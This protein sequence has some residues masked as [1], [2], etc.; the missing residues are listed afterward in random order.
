MEHGQQVT[1][2][3]FTLLGE[4]GALTGGRKDELRRR[5]T[6]Y[7]LAS[8]AMSIGGGTTEVNLNV[9]GERILGLPRDPEPGR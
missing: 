7:L 8:R 9:I 2:F 1:E 3:G 5:W 6:R 4:E